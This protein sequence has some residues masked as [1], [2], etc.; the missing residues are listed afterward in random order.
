MKTYTL[1]LVLFCAGA[2]FGQKDASTLV[3]DSIALKKGSHKDENVAAYYALHKGDALPSKAIGTVGKGSLQ[4][5]KLIPYYG[6]NY[7]YFD[8]L[9]YFE[10]RA[11]THEL[12]RDIILNSYDSLAQLCD[13]HFYLMELSN[14]EGGKMFPHH[15]HQNG[16]SVDFMMPMLKEGKTYTGLD[17]LGADHYWLKFDNSGKWTEDP[18]VSVDFNLIARQVLILDAEAKKLGLKVAK[19]IVKIEY[20][21]ELFETEYGKQLKESGIYVV[22]KLTPMVNELHDEHFHIDFEKR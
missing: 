18:R 19:L 8:S 4:N 1:L 21:D 16:M 12:V 17:T 7:T 20:K 10:G 2:L 14:K 5:G 3:S 15:T 13:N 9:S 6:K 11:F 22:Q